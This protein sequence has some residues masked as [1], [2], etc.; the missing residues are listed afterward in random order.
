MI[1]ILLAAALAGPDP[2]YDKVVRPFLSSH[3]FKCHGPKRQKGKLR[4]DTLPAELSNEAT[5][6][7]WQRIIDQLNLGEMPPEEEKR[8]PAKIAT[9]V[10]AWATGR[11]R[12]AHE[13]LKPAG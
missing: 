9:Q 2:T 6:K 1:D 10:I 11:V 3:C 4:F 12:L 8:P 5:L 7:T 13:K